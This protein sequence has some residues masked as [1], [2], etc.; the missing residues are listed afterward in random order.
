MRFPMKNNRTSTEMD[1]W[2]YR[3]PLSPIKMNKNVSLIYI[4][5]VLVN[6]RKIISYST[7]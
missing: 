6:E 3:L 5:R 1:F 7:F 2:E 4:H